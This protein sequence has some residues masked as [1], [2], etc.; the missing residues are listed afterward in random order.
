MAVQPKFDKIIELFQK[1]RNFE[2]TAEQYKSK[3]G[4]EF[5]KGK[6]YAEKR[7]AVAKR[8]TEY[9]YEITVVPLRIQFRKIK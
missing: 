6:S 3:T 2:L 5:P 8:A 7:S 9:G 4:A 1:G